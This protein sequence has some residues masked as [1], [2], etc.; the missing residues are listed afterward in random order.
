MAISHVNTQ[1][2]TAS[3][4]TAVSV[5]KPTGL[6][7]NDVLIFAIYANNNTTVS[8]NNGA[9]PAT[10][11]H[12]RLAADSS[13]R[14]SLYSRVAGGSEPASYSFTLSASNRWGIVCSAYRGV[15][16]TTL[17]DDAPSDTTSNS[18][19]GSSTGT[20]P[21]ITSAID[22]VMAIAIGAF[23]DGTHDFSTFP[24][25]SYTLGG[26]SGVNQP[27]SL[28][29][30]LLGAQPVTQNGVSWTTSISPCFITYQ[31]SL[32]PAATA[33]VVKSFAALGV[34]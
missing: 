18:T 5:T 15:D 29:Y 11:V 1:T 17:Y 2:G 20:S 3:T 4:G 14:I 10:A 6:A 13:A 7:A 26:N 22:G 23:D 16:T 31:F 30:K 27:V 8:D 32:N 9:T 19:T 33:V 34:G 24:G 28:S 21:A 12:S 25:D